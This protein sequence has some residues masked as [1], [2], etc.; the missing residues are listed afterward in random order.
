MTERTPVREVKH[1]ML[2]PIAGIRLRK[3]KIVTAQEAVDIIRDGDTVV[4]AG[5]IRLL[6]R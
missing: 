6:T 1:P 5:F 3:G 4:T 2:D